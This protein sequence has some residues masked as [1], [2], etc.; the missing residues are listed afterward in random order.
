MQYEKLFD[1]Y[2]K[3]D[4]KKLQEIS[5]EQEAGSEITG[6][7]MLSLVDQ[8]NE[9]MVSRLVVKLKQKSSFIAVGALHLPGQQG[10]LNLLANQGFIIQ[11]VE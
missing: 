1:A 6:K 3:H 8:R 5:A 2:L 10:I 9:R 7:I 4:L 11:K